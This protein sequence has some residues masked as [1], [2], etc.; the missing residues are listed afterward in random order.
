MKEYIAV[1]VIVLLLPYVV[2]ML[3]QGKSGIEGTA[4]SYISEN[5]VGKEISAKE[6]EFLIGALAAAIPVSYPVE[7]LKAQAVILRTQYMEEEEHEKTYSIDEMKELWGAEDFPDYYARL[8]QAVEETQGQILT[9]EGKVIYAPYHA[10]SAGYT[11]PAESLFAEGEYPYL[12]SAECKTDIEAEGYLSIEYVSAEDFVK[13]ITASFPECQL[14]ADS[15]FMEL[16]TKKMDKAGYVE[17][18][19]VGTKELSGEV[20]R[21]AMGFP[22]ASFTIEEYEGNVRIVTKGLGHGLGFDQYYARKLAQ[23]G[24][25]MSEIINYF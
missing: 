2:T 13:R 21:R 9:Y 4:V 18:I 23:D 14:S 6:E 15:L 5:Q 12:K 1:L 16:N 3:Y 7:T 24:K 10:V 11:R 19:A 8:K 22:S 25:K 17:T 20:F